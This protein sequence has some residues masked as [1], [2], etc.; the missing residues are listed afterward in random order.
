MSDTQPQQIDAVQKINASVF[1]NFDQQFRRDV[2]PRH[3]Q[4]AL[5]CCG[6]GSG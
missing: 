1:Q 3:F 4:R 6:V 5:Q 2:A